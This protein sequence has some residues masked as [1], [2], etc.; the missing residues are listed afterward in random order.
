M[1]DIAKVGNTTLVFNDD[2]ADPEKAEEIL[3]RIG[4]IYFNDLLQQ[5]LLQQEKNK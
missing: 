5:K 4:E 1:T 2:N 3:R